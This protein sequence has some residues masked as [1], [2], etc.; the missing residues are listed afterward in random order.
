MPRSENVFDTSGFKAGTWKMPTEYSFN[1]P[2]PQKYS[3]EKLADT[4]YVVKPIKTKNLRC[5]FPSPHSP[6]QTA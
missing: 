1:D 3:N 5:Y 2:V 4:D 6:H